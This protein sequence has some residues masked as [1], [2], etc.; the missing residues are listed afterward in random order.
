MT[1]LRLRHASLLRLGLAGRAGVQM[2]AVLEAMPPAGEPGPGQAAAAAGGGVGGG[3]G[4][5]GVVEVHRASAE[6]GEELRLAVLLPAG[7]YTLWFEQLE[8]LE[9]GGGAAAAGCDGVEL[10][11]AI[12]PLPAPLPPLPSTPTS[13]T[14]GKPLAAALARG[15]AFE[16]PLSAA[17]YLATLPAGGGAAGGGA[18]GGEMA[19]GG[20]EQV[21]W[22]EAFAVAVPHGM[23]AMHVVL[24]ADA[25]S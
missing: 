6:E 14:L 17:T 19:G 10:E 7:S 13:P 3:G 25:A 15:A 23:V 24:L 16:L 20:R 8:E 11:L 4:G 9:V 1:E 18:A 21:V 5:G 12:E 22:S 2:A